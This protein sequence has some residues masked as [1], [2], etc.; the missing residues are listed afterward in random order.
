MYYSKNTG[1]FYDTEIH[2]ANMPDDVVEISADE[3]AMLLRGQSNGQIIAANGNGF[4]TLADMPE[5]TTGEL[6]AQCKT[7]AKQLLIKSDWTQQADV[8][9]VLINKAEFDDFRVI[10]RDL[11]LRPVPAPEF[12]ETPDAVWN[13]L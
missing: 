11:F 12:P 2:G 10:V 1:G 8:A 3:H 13:T 5:P 6:L 9:N 7:R 4:P